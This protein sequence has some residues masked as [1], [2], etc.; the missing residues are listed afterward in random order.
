M[1]MA[2]NAGVVLAQV[3]LKKGAKP[4]TSLKEVSGTITTRVLV[5]GSLKAID[6]PFTLKSVPLP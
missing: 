6:V 2:G 1:G 4:A 3:R 5:G